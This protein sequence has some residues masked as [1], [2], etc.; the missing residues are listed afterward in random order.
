GSSEA[1][2][3]RV[4]GYACRSCVCLV[5]DRRTYS[6]L[7]DAGPVRRAGASPSPAAARRGI[8]GPPS[9]SVAGRAADPAIAEHAVYNATSVGYQFRCCSPLVEPVRSH[10]PE[11]RRRLVSAW[12]AR[13]RST[14]KS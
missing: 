1:Q 3:E 6:P 12:T 9:Q 10:L 13:A 7:S 11:C 2:T 14:E 4:A 8:A 5:L